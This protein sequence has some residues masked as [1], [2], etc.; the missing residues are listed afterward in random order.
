MLIS[1]YENFPHIAG[2]QV[3]LRKVV[4]GDLDA[5]CEL[6]ASEAVFRY[7]PGDVKK[8]RSTVQNMIGHFERDFHKKKEIFLG[9]CP[10]D[11]PGRLV[12]L[13]ELFDY[14]ARIGGIT[15]GYRICAAFW[16]RGFATWTVKAATGY[17]FK[18]TGVNRIQ[19]FVM[20]E[21]AASCRVLLKNG[22]QR[23]G[24]LRQSQYWKG[25]GIVDLL[26]F[27]RLRSDLG[28]PSVP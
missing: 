28:T 14:D 21:N 3:V 26:L 8:N 9:I 19:A 23:E 16:G 22:F 25:R 18:E 11:E 24:L 13:C 4:D 27:S 7:I 6:Y 20:P 2:E 1:P 5:L 15:L 12:G 10:A 17:L